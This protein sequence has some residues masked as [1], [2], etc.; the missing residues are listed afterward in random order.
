VG[1]KVGSFTLV[2]LVTVVALASI[3]LFFL[4][5]LNVATGNEI[6]QI[7]TA[8]LFLASSFDEAY[9]QA[10]ASNTYVKIFIDTS[11]DLKF[12]R[13]AI[14]KQTKNTWKTEREIILPE[15]TF[16]LPLDEFSKYLDNRDLSAYAY[17]EG[18]VILHGE[19]IDGY[20]FVF[21]PEGHLSNGTTA[22]FGIGYGAKVGNDIKLKK[23][24]NIYGLFIAATGRRII[25]NS[26]N[27]IKEAI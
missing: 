12:R 19:T 4:V 3:F 5:K 11:S 13:V 15:R 22:I 6:Q 1:R 21:G 23:D 25:L 16:V 9:G 26:K 14:I 2:E 8:A 27:A 24:A 10:I 18:K 7:K 17:A 20:C